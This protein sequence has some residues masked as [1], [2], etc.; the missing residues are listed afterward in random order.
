MTLQECYAALEGDYSGV[1]GRLGGERIVN[2]FVIRFLD[3]KSFEQLKESIS[4]GRTEEAFRA[5]HTLKGVCQNLGFSL[6]YGSS[7]AVTE[8]LRGGNI[9]EAERLLPETESNYNQTVSAI[10]KYK[11]AIG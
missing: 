2:K 4:D 9:K 3:D 8:A 5:A 7:S 1:T 10:E 11:S 6:L